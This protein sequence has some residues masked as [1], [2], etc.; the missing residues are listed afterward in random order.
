ME[1]SR[2]RDSSIECPVCGETFELE[3]IYLHGYYRHDMR[4]ADWRKWGLRQVECPVCGRTCSISFL[5]DHMERHKHESGNGG[6]HATVVYYLGLK[7]CSRCLKPLERVY[8]RIP[9][10][11]LRCP[12]CGE[13]WPLNRCR[14]GSE[15]MPMKDDCWLGGDTLD[16][17]GKYCMAREDVEALTATLEQL[18]YRDTADW[19][20]RVR[21]I[22]SELENACVEEQFNDAAEELEGLREA[23]LDMLT[24]LALR[25]P[26]R[27]Y[28]PS[29]RKPAA[30]ERHRMRIR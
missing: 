30:R 6:P 18:G 11:E 15:A 5:S 1:S 19:R 23:M 26:R 17:Y 8:D 28:H 21:G 20:E 16:A 13:W 14:P 24:S 2:E 7:S 9:Y 3:S 29:A 22:D 27:S 4:A 25:T 10:C 12:E